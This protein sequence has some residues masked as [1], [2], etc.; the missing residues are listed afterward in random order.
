[1]K[2]QKIFTGLLVL[3]IAISVIGCGNVMEKLNRLQIKMHKDEVVSLFGTSFIA[4]ASKVDETGNVLDLWEM[5]DKKSK[6]TYQIYFLKH[7][8]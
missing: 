5:Y 4:K 1:M 2:S 8:I 6:S 3:F 7:L